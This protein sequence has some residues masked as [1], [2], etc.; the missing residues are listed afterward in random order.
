MS[1][2]LSWVLPL[3]LFWIL[4]ALFMR[5][6]GAPITVWGLAGV[7]SVIGLVVGISEDIVWLAILAA[8]V[9]VSSLVFL[10][11]GSHE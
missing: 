7:A 4:W 2:V 1:T 11:R 3:A 10:R 5:A 9:L 6:I 8:A